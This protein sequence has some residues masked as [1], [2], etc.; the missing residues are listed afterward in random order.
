MVKKKKKNEINE[1]IF[2][3]VV[4]WGQAS[5][6]DQE[7]P[8]KDKQVERNGSALTHQSFIASME[9]QLH[10]TETLDSSKA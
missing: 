6:L 9:S 2:L 1:Y 4:L 5:Q 8:A 10:D 7:S 3:R